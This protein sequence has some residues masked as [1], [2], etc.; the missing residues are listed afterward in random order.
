MGRSAL[1]QARIR[2]KPTSSIYRSWRAIN[3]HTVAEANCAAS[4]PI[5]PSHER[6]TLSDTGFEEIRVRR[7]NHEYGLVKEAE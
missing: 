5:D 1:S 3:D 2:L 7:L 4:L 6:H